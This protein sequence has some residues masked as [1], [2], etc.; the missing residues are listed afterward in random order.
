MEILINSFLM[1]VFAIV[2]VFSFVAISAFAKE[3]RMVRILKKVKAVEQ[4]KKK[5]SYETYTERS[6]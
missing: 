4:N 5:G 3:Q 2:T 6:Y 1:I